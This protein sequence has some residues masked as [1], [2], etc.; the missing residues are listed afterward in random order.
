[1]RPL[2]ILTAALVCA[3]LVIVVLQRDA[4]MDFAASLTG[5]AE[6][7]ETAPEAPDAGTAPVSISESSRGAQSEAV[8][9]TVLR[10]AAR[11]VPDA[12]MV[13]G[14]TDAAREVTAAAETSGTVVSEPIRKGAFVEA[15]DVLCELDP[16]TRGASLAE[17]EAALAEAR[18]R[19]P[20]A[21]ARVPQAQ[22]VVAEA[23]ARLEEA[24]LNQNAA[25]RLSEGGYASE[26]QVA[27]ASA[28]LRSAEAGVE[29]ARTGLQT[30]QAGIEAA[31]AGVQS[32]EAAVERARLEI[33]N[34]SI[35]APFAG[36]LESDTAELGTLLQAGGACATVVQLDPVKLVG[37]L[38]EAQ[39]D[40]V[41]T[42][43]R[44][45]ARLASGG[46]ATGEVTYVSR[47]ADDLTRTFRVEVT[48]PNPDLAI[49]DGQTAEIMIETPTRTAHLLPSSSLTLD[50]EGRLGVRAVED[51]VATFLPVTLL[52]DSTEG[53]Y[54]AGLPDAVDVIVVGQEY[55]TEGVPV[56]VSYAEGMDPEALADAPAAETGGVDPLDA[57]EPLQ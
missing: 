42:G 49:R 4:L 48:V 43:A 45:G 56:R 27:N 15:G 11:E 8:L 17:A 31:G 35:E 57:A 24:R 2:S 53:V 20:E 44:A 14:Q 26:T 21:E 37:F 30:V 16:G 23:E 55:V 10:S 34:L 32:A 22:A 46:D 33:E 52:R 13:R 25:S 6:T 39:V 50:D 12:V 1:M 29:A 7:A 5:T 18:S 40:R 41:E 28:A 54:V 51:G 36:F 3:A 9:V 19:V 38:P 47:A